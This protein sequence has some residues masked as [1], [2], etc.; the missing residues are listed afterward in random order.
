LKNFQRL[1]FLFPYCRAIVDIVFYFR[2]GGDTNHVRKRW[3]VKA[4]KKDV[5]GGGQ[6]SPAE[7]RWLIRRSNLKSIIDQA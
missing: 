2:P 4:E 1:S 6:P 3:N 7:T 5:G